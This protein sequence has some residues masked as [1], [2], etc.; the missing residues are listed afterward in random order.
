MSREPRGPPR[1][2]LA[3]LA[4]LALSC[5]Q[6]SRVVRRPEGLAA[7]TS[8]KQLGVDTGMS[9]PRVLAAAD[10]AAVVIGARKLAD[11]LGLFRAT[12]DAAGAL[13][14]FV[15][16]T[17]GLAYLKG[18]ALDADGSVYV[19]YVVA[20]DVSVVEKLDPSMAT[21][22]RSQLDLFL[23]PLALDAGVLW[24][25]GFSGGTGT[26][27]AQPAADALVRFDAATGASAMFTVGEGISV[28]TVVADRAGGV[29]A[30][31]GRAAIGDRPATTFV[32]RYSPDGGMLWGRDLPATWGTPR[33]SFR[34][35]AL[36]VAAM[37]EVLRPYPLD[38]T[39]DAAVMQLDAD[40]NTRWSTTF[41]TTEVETVEGAAVDASGAAWVVGSTYGA[42]PG[43]GRAADPGGDAFVARLDAS[44]ALLW[45]TQLGTEAADAASDVALGPAGDAYVV[46]R[47][48]GTFPGNTSDPGV[49][50]AR[51]TPD[52]A[53]R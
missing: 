21:L 51:V 14:G 33:I 18:A 31:G 38:H 23:G 43:S 20:P 27:G 48:S 42:F 47:T 9:A 37:V 29:F 6:G 15:G 4:V 2:A 19:S 34:D 44:G 49:F 28:A 3:M 40:G 13:I 5:D 16:T 53:L 12:F 10:G 35:G 50:L 52:G 8:V 32:A 41:G 17:A 25:P 24:T 22:W 39:Y 1:A 46:G 26:F 45:T 36:V 11:G 7:P 30:T